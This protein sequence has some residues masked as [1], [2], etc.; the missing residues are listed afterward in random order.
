MD[1]GERN[2]VSGVEDTN[3]GIVTCHLLK[4]E[5]WV[6]WDCVQ[7]VRCTHGGE[8]RLDSHTIL[9]MVIDTVCKVFAVPM[10]VRHAWIRIRFF[11]WFRATLTSWLYTLTKNHMKKRHKE[12]RRFLAEIGLEAF[13]RPLL[14]HRNE[15]TRSGKRV[16]N[17]EIIPKRG[18]RYWRRT[19]RRTWTWACTTPFAWIWNLKWRVYWTRRRDCKSKG[20]GCKPTNSWRH[21]KKLWSV[22][23][24]KKNYRCKLR[25]QVHS[26]PKPQ[27]RERE[28]SRVLRGWFLSLQRGR[29]KGLECELRWNLRARKRNFNI[30]NIVISILYLLYES[31][32]CMTFFWLDRSKESLMN[33]L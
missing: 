21:G 17:V 24:M 18:N 1:W 30:Q 13:K 4:P 26:D 32:C 25:C 23:M 29:Q 6:N 2:E 10:E 27:R 28:L 22:Q 15:K 5:A 31:K 19:W 33:S 20:N 11:S 8:A 12:Y 7:S 14:T 16:G 9:L 3:S